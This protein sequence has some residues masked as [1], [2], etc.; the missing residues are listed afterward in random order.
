VVQAQI[1]AG[2]VV[3]RPASVVKEL[4]ENA[5]DA[6]ARHVEVVLQGGGIDGIL[7][8]DDG[9]GMAGP[10]ALLAFARHATSKVTRL[11]DLEGV[12][13]LGFR[14]EALP[15]IA[16][17]ASVRLVTRRREDAGA[18]VVE[19]DVDGARAGGVAGAP[20]GT[21]VDVRGLF[22]DV[23]A[24]RKFLRAPAT[25]VGHV[26]ETLTRLAAAAPGVGFRLEHA[27]REV[28]ALPP[29]RDLGTRLAQVLERGR[30][31]ALVPVQAEIGGYSLTGFLGRPSE[32]LASARL[33]WTY[34]RFGARSDAPVAGRW[35][36][37]RLLLRAVLDGYASLVMR[38]RYPLAMLFLG[39]PAGEVDVNVHPAKLEVRFR[40]PNAI[41][42]LVVPALRQRLAEGLAP[43]V[44]DPVEVRESPPA[45]VFFAPVRDDETP[46]PGPATPATGTLW[47]TAPRGFAALRFVGQLFDG[48]LLCE[49]EGRVVLVDQHAAHERVVFER[50]RAEAQASGVARDRLLV[51]ETVTLPAAH[52]AT[53]AE[54]GE[55]LEAAGLEGEAFGEDTWILRTVPR[56]VRGR[57]VGELLRTLA[58]ELAEEGA[59][60]AAERARDATLARIA[61]HSVVRV[62]QR[63]DAAEVRALLEAMDG[64]E[65]VAH[66][67]HGRPVAAELTRAQLEALFRR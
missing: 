38:G 17:V 22:A 30:H 7:V 51:P 39:V 50:L 44:G 16:S 3:E 14:G 67:P 24:R 65:V 25:E 46:A 48:Y 53:L 37:D 4:V 52:V 2:E 26:A 54:H 31:A 36:R 64:V 19:A 40:R 56:L 11:E 62:G 8:R 32:T 45:Y 43:T 34:V 28:L 1:A 15:S 23:P 10:D 41:H 49:G 6:G 13:T 21:T 9:E 58:A 5:L 27:G 55:A 18:A 61:C 59:S 57:D 60:A 42:T 33:I 47:A 29:V 20:V 66:C 35:I 12:G 63:L